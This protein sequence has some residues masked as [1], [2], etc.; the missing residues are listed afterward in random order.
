MRHE[1]RA[2]G[3]SVT[4]ENVDDPRR[5]A[6][7]RDE[8]RESQCRER[9]LLGRFQDTGAT[10]GECRR[11]LPRGHR[12]RKVPRDDLADHADGFA[13][14]IRV[15]L[16]ARWSG[17][18]VEGGAFDLGRPARHVPEVFTRTGNVDDAG[19]EP[20]LAV[21]E[22]LEFTEFVEVGIDQIG[23]LPQQV[24][25]ERGL[26]A[27][28]LRRLECRAGRL[29][30]TIDVLRV[31]VGHAGDLALTCRV[32]DR[33]L[34]AGRRIYPLSA[35]EQFLRTSQKTTDDF[36]RIGLLRNRGTHADSSLRQA[37]ACVSF[38]VS[39]LASSRNTLSAFV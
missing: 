24:L 15:E 34:V 8:F 11:D 32:D 25:P 6:G 5:E 22:T 12:Q 7:L 10:G 3:L 38:I 20:G 9:R 26:G 16:H 28:P 18:H 13:P 27:G 39:W 36:G 37:R 23:Q 19:H 4:G 29:H 14:R 21:V 30:G 17:G 31:R 1:R 2:R 33:Y 35:D